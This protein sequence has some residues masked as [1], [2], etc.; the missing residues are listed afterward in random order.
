MVGSQGFATW[1]GEFS[2]NATFNSTSASVQGCAKRPCLFNISSDP[3]EHH[4]LSLALPDQVSRLTA[5][6]NSY[7]N[8]FHPGGPKGA[9]ESGYCSAAAKNGG[10]MVPWRP[11]PAEDDS[12]PW[13]G[14]PLDGMEVGSKKWDA[15]ILGGGGSFLDGR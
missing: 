6:F 5:I 3:T 13:G 10:F 9:D 11:E 12:A 4:D 8:A 1:F 7:N 14:D 2:P 15:F